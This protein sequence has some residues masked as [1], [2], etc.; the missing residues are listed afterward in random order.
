MNSLRSL[1]RICRLCSGPTNGTSVD[2]LHPS[3]THLRHFVYL[4]FGINVILIEILFGSVC[5]ATLQL[6][7]GFCISIVL[8]I[9]G[10]EGISSRLCADCHK[11]VLENTAHYC[12]VQNAQMKIS[13]AKIQCNQRQQSVSYI[14][15]Y[16]FS[17]K[18]L[19]VSLSSPECGAHAYR[20]SYY[21]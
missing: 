16:I 1:Q 11:V 12:R 10:Q 4:F 15:V 9:T 17:K 6:F 8:Q 21:V 18:F 7:C 13:A 5:G 20:S 19:S 2:C 3:H 14:P